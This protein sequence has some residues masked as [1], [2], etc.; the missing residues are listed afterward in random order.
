MAAEIERRD[1][2]PMRGSFDRMLGP[3]EL[4]DCEAVATDITRL[5]GAFPEEPLHVRDI[6]QRLDVEVERSFGVRL[7]HRREAD[8]VRL[9][10][11]WTIHLL[12]RL[13]EAREA[14]VIGHELGHWYFRTRG[15]RPDCEEARCDAIGA[16][17]VAPRPPFADA[18]RILGHRVHELAA[19]FHT[20]QGLALLRLGEVTGRP[21]LLRLGRRDVVRGAPFVWGHD[22]FGLP[23]DVAHRISVDGSWG[24]MVDRGWQEAA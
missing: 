20:M 1:Y 4:I 12:M 3:D 7:G 2:L 16:C 21:V 17:L 9:G 19:A 8:I 11:V 5:A 13:T 14:W 23:R 15:L 10:S 6:A 24:M 18:A 22:P